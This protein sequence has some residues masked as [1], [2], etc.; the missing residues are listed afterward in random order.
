MGGGSRGLLWKL[1]LVTGGGWHLTRCQSLIA[2]GL[3]GTP[4]G[5]LYTWGRQEKRLRKKG[6][7]S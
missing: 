7:C 2:K 5:W 3:R 6:E 1:L 4:Q